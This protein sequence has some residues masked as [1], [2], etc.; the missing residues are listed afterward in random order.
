[1]KSVDHLSIEFLRS[2]FTFDAETGE[3]RWRYRDDMSAQWNGRYAGKIAGNRD[4]K[5]TRYV[6]VSVND[7]LYAAHRIIWA[8]VTGAWPTNEIDHRDTDGKNNKFTNLREATRSQN[9]GN[10][11]LSRA[12]TSGFKWVSWNKKR[13]LWMALMQINNAKI[14]VGFGHDPKQL[15]ESCAVIAK[16]N[17]KEFA[18]IA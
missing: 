5:G 6:W 11:K 10:A 2:V 13:C 17:R 8:V 3:L 1:M 14:I 4:S 12:N 9:L 15:H 18:R 7:I 16:Q